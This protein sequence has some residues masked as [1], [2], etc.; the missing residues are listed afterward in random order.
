MC[1][2]GGGRCGAALSIVCSPPL[3]INGS[4]GLGHFQSPLSSSSGQRWPVVVACRA[5]AIDILLHGRSDK[6]CQGKNKLWRRVL[7]GG[8]AINVQHL[9]IHGFPCESLKSVLE[10][11]LDS[12]KTAV[13]SLQE[14]FI[15]FGLLE[16]NT[17]FHQI[18][19][20][21]REAENEPL[22]LS[23]FNESQSI[24][25]LSPNKRTGHRGRKRNPNLVWSQ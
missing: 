18:N 17:V 3:N 14:Y 8:G 11:S 7:F 5:L 23:D 6:K 2:V 19:A 9:R 21:G 13:C 4:V 15:P 24:Y 1:G 10:F 22:S 16:S 25:R 12:S 20:L